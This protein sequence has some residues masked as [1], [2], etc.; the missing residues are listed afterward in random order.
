MVGAGPVCWIS[1]YSF[2]VRKTTK[3]EIYH[4]DVVLGGRTVSLR[5]Q[6]VY[7]DA[8]KQ[9]YKLG[10]NGTNYK[11]KAGQKFHTTLGKLKNLTKP[12]KSKGLISIKS[13]P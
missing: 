5:L 11:D 3:E 4:G 10:I 9:E 12:S 7:V 13:K 2:V 1:S 6:S 8:T